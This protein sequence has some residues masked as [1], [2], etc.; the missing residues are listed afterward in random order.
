[1]TPTTFTATL[2]ARGLSQARFA[3][4]TRTHATTVS[5]WATGGLPVPGWVEAL[6]DAWELCPEALARAIRRAE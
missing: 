5:R 3:R 6:L 1:M 2:S 4:L